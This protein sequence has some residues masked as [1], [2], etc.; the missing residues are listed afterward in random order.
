MPQTGSCFQGCWSWFGKNTADKPN[1]SENLPS[2]LANLQT[3]LDRKNLKTSCAAT[4]PH[5]ARP[6]QRDLKGRSNSKNSKSCQE[7]VTR[8]YSLTGLPL[9]VQE[10]REREV[11]YSL[12]GMRLPADV[13][14]CK[15]ASRS[16]AP[17]CTHGKQALDRKG[18]KDSMSSKEGRYSLTGMPLPPDDDRLLRRPSYSLTGMLLPIEEGA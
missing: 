9:P 10:Q 4:H 6:R 1:P 15:P 12:T 13:P 5:A 18:S 2:L 17:D 14:A 7:T 11:T 8:S 16:D 3:E